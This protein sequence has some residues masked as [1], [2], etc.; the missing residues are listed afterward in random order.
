MRSGAK[1]GDEV[2]MPACPIIK[3]LPHKLEVP[4]PEYLVY[5]DMLFLKDYRLNAFP[6][7]TQ[8]N[9]DEDAPYETWLIDY[10]CSVDIELTHEQRIIAEY[11]RTNTDFN[12]S[13]LG[14]LAGFY[15][16]YSAR[17]PYYDYP[18]DFEETFDLDR[19]ESIF[20]NPCQD[21]LGRG[22]DNND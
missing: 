22:E 12:A 17:H 4:Y 13:R 8:G 21:Y 1:P 15:E 16:N 11:I 20:D 6:K 5:G 14:D 18:E 9:F 10:L 3:V 7:D 2:T 19:L